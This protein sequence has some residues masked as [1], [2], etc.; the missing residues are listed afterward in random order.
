[1]EKIVKKLPKSNFSTLCKEMEAFGWEILNQQ[2]DNNYI[3]ITFSRDEKIK[4]IE[5]IKKLEEAYFSI[6]L[7]PFWPIIFFS[8]FSFILYTVYFVLA[9]I[10]KKNFDYLL[11]S[12]SILLPA[13]LLLLSATIYTGLRF[14][15]FKIYSMNENNNKIAIIRKAKELLNDKE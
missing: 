11:Y 1:M 2:D 7:L 4:N 3:L 13:T 6:K 14:K 8:V 9:L 10:Y 5:E 15:S 12:L